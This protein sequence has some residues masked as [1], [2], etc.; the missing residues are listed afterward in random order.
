M[1]RVNEKFQRRYIPQFSRPT[2]KGFKF[3]KEILKEIR[4]LFFDEDGSLKNSICNDIDISMN[5]G[6]SIYL[7]KYTFSFCS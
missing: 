4:D 2:I 3:S 7:Y 1:N 6:E 5:N